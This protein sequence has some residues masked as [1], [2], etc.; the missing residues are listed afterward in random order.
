[1]ESTKAGSRWKFKMSLHTSFRFDVTFM[2]E[3]VN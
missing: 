2:A 3:V 1:M